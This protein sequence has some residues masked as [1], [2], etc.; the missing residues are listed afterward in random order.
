MT[1]GKFPGGT[2]I[3]LVY[4][5]GM[6]INANTSE[7]LSKDTRTPIINPIA[8]K[9]VVPATMNTIAGIEI[10]EI[11][12]D[13][14]NSNPIAKNNRPWIPPTKLLPSTYPKVIDRLELG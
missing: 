2:K 14:E 1:G 4:T 13:G 8:P 11:V 12:N 10:T 3:V 5:K 9:K 7:K 6:L